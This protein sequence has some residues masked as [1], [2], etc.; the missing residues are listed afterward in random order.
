MATER[1][2]TISLR[3]AN[4]AP[5]GK[6]AQKAARYIRDFLKKHTKSETIRI[7]PSLNEQIWEDGGKRLKPRIQIKTTTEEDGVVKAAPAE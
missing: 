6:R 7:D 5:R 3:D 2:Y 4:R 1:L